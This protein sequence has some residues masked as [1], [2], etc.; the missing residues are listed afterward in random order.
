MSRCIGVNATT[1]AAADSNQLV[2]GASGN[3]VATNGGATTYYATAGASLGYIQ[4]RLNGA[5]VKIQV[6]AP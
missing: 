4:V 5:N 2:I 3:Y 1:A 6:F